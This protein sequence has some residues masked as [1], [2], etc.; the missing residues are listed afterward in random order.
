LLAAAVA[1]D[2]S[3]SVALHHRNNTRKSATHLACS[4]GRVGCAGP[5]AQVGLLQE[6][7]EEEEEERWRIIISWAE[8]LD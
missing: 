1:L 2:T 5:A 8:E 3:E 6:E 7:E 4:I